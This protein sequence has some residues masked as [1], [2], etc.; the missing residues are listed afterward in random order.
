MLDS[1]N[2]TNL[3]LD[4]GFGPDYGPDNTPVRAF[5]IHFAEAF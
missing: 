3:R 1:E 4:F 2:R 5:Y